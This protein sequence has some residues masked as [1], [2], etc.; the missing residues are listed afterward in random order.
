MKMMIV[1]KHS[2]V[3]IMM[4]IIGSS[5]HIHKYGTVVYVECFYIGPRVPVFSH[6]LSEYYLFQIN[7]AI[8][9]S[10][11]YHLKNEVN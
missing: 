6:I 10:S 4:L 8:I 1:F 7:N 5:T 3:V 2:K 11:I 9:K